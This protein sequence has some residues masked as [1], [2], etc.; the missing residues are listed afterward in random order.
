VLG[1]HKL[2]Y[3]GS[4]QGHA[5][6]CCE[7]SN[8]HG[9]S[10]VC[11]EFLDYLWNCQ[12][13]KQDSAPQSELTVIYRTLDETLKLKT[14]ISKFLLLNRRKSCTLIVSLGKVSLIQITV[15]HFACAVFTA[16][17]DDNFS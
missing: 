2:K 1:G 12:F 5:A 16:M 17:Q 6:G 8:E 3:C 7:H 15:W 11:G 10:I 4:E 9:V 14:L 13:L